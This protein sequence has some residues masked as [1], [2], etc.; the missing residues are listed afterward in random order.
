MDK[1]VTEHFF[2][3]ALNA[4]TGYYRVSGNYLSYGVIGAMLMDL[5]LNDRIELDGKDIRIRQSGISGLPVYDKMLE[6]ISNSEKQRSIRFWLRKFAFKATW[7]RK[8]LQ[9]LLVNNGK[10]KQERKRFLAIPYSLYYPADRSETERLVF[11]L[12]DIILYNKQAEEHE[13]MFLGLV[14]ACRMHRS[15]SRESDERRKLRKALVRYIK[16]NPVASG[17]SKTIMEMQAAIT[18]S[19]AAA[20]IASNAASSSH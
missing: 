5:A 6:T 13:L 1:K 15:L 11:R 7:Y 17:V 14:Y 20:V 9:K 4:E 12:K 19:I 18:A 3:L 10:L 2:Q 8:E 16:E